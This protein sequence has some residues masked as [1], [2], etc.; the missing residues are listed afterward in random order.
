MPLEAVPERLRAAV[1]GVLAKWG[2]VWE[3]V[4]FAGTAILAASEHW[5]LEPGS[6]EVW[7]FAVT[8]G[9]LSVGDQLE[10]AGGRAAGVGVSAFSGGVIPVTPYQAR[11]YECLGRG[12]PG[13]TPERRPAPP[14]PTTADTAPAT[15]DPPG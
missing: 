11:V 3:D 1:S 15:P 12:G 7:V 5:R 13:R 4:N 10:L 9:Q 8:A 14:S 2:Y 6:E